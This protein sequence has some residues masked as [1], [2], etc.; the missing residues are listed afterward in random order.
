MNEAL[1][2]SWAATWARAGRE[3]EALRWHELASMTEDQAREA[4]ADL[5]SIPLPEDLPSR[6]DSG[7][8]EQQRWFARLRRDG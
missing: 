7:L 3:L 8:V 1:L 2:R 6:S 4:A 5:L